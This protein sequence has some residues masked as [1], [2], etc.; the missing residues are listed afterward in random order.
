MTSTNTLLATL[1]SALLLGGSAFASDTLQ[2]AQA[3]AEPQSRAA[4]REQARTSPPAAGV[5]SAQPA[6]LG[7]ASAPSRAA[8]RANAAKNK[9]VAGAQSDVGSSAVQSQG[10]RA[11]VREQ[12]RKAVKAGAGPKGGETTN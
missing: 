2:V 7:A 12:T 10:S 8:V 1:A 3:S 5:A 9:P 11:Q 6:P 4:V